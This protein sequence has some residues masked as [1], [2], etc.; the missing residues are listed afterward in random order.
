[1]LHE[2]S[3]R[4]AAAEATRAAVEREAAA[5]EARACTASTWTCAGSCQPR[6]PVEAQQ[7]STAAKAKAWLACLWGGVALCGDE[8]IVRGPGHW[9][10]VH[11]CKSAEC[12]LGADTGDRGMQGSGP[13]SATPL[14]GMPAVPWLMAGSSSA[15]S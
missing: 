10:Q 1:M 14:A 8:G 3:C 12:W 15:V 13:H 9:W 7:R 4:V 6:K 2:P 11:A 5:A